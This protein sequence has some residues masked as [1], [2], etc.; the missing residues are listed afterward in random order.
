MKKMNMRNRGDTGKSYNLYHREALGEKGYK[1]FW[2]SK[3]IFI[4]KKNRLQ[5]LVFVNL[6]GKSVDEG[7]V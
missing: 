7:R 1:T 2:A 5:S 4:N 3:R 6:I